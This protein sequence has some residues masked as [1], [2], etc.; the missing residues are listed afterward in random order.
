M[1][2][3]FTS[4]FVVLAL[5]VFVPLI[6]H[7]EDAKVDLVFTANARGMVG[8]GF[9]G[10]RARVKIWITGWTS[11]EAEDVLLN[12]LADKGM[13]TLVEM[14]RKEP[15]VGYVQVDTDL[16]YPLRYAQ[17]METD[18]GMEIVLATDRPLD[19]SEFWESSRT[20]QYSISLISLILDE[21]GE[22]SGSV[23]LGAKLRAN[24]ENRTLEIE[25]YGLHP[26]RLFSVKPQK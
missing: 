26:I 7:A 4:A 14:L 2:K 12:N 6:C 10:E 24:K 17:A 15:E 23:V 19:F 11:N 1:R 9:A 21:K 3:R 22:G 8:S 25:N 13:E 16:R 18:D 5:L 20:L